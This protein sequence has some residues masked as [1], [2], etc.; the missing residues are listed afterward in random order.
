MCLFKKDLFLKYINK[1][2]NAEYY[3]KKKHISFI[4][5]LPPKSVYKSINGFQINKSTDIIHGLNSMCLCD[6][7][8]SLTHNPTR[9]ILSYVNDNRGDTFHIFNITYKEIKTIDEINQYDIYN[10]IQDYIYIYKKIPSNEILTEQ[11]MVSC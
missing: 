10:A 3:N 8:I 5:N 4:G 1:Q 6:I 7:H 2:K 11:I 9:L